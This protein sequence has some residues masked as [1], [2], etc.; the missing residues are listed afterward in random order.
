MRRIV[1]LFSLVVLASNT[2]LSFAGT[3]TTR[4][5]A[6]EFLNLG[7]GGQSLGMGGA[8]VAVTRDVTAGY[9]NPAGLAFIDYPEIML[10]HSRQFS[11]AVNYNYGSIGLPVGRRSSLGLTVIRLGVD[12]IKK[13]GLTN[14]EVG[15]GEYYEDENGQVVQNRSIILDTFGN[16]DYAFFLTYAK[17][18]SQHFSYGGNVKFINRVLGDN[19]AW[20]VGFDVGFMFNAT[21][22][23][24]VGINLQDI[25]STLVAWDT[26]SRELI[27][28]S[29]K[30]GLTYPVTVSMMGGEMQPAL[31]FLIHF[32]NLRANSLANLGRASVDVNMGWEYVYNNA[33]ALRLG[34]SNVGQTDVQMDFGRFS[35]G[36][37]LRLPKLD[38]DYAFLG[39]EELGTTH[40]ISARL[41]LEELKFKRSE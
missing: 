12:D 20:G 3:P 37:G 40:R 38:I 34:F 41:S 26:G 18:V 16:A 7:A 1:C 15:L 8:F 24:I 32:E 22:N 27:T 5:Y 36:V 35:A 2:S 25:T 4:K 13:V 29:I 19:S 17:R 28:P 30:A 21:S 23:L 14:P 6:G 11:D 39:H 10:M 33:L 9:W 31:D